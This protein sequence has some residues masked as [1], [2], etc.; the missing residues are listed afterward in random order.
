MYGKVPLIF[1]R[2]PIC[3][4]HYSPL[5]LYLLVDL[6]NCY[7]VKSILTKFAQISELT[8]IAS[9]TCGRDVCRKPHKT[10]KHHTAI[11]TQSAS[12]ASMRVVT[13][14]RPLVLED[15]PFAIWISAFYS[16]I[17]KF[18]STRLLLVDLTHGNKRNYK[19]EKC[20]SSFQT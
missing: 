3:T 4:A 12:I 20:F 14:I 17:L 19:Q 10:L 8:W 18:T 13:V 5:S 15:L 16:K 2:I 1:A 7:K 6:T 11:C 9:Q